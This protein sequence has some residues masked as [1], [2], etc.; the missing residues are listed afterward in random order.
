MG[1]EEEEAVEEKNEECPEHRA[2]FTAL[3]DNLRE[4][5]HDICKKLESAKLGR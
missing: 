1:S 2:L 5:D 4:A 3:S